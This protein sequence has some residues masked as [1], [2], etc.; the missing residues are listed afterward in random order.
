[1]RSALFTLLAFLYIPTY[2]VSICRLGQNDKP[3]LVIADVTAKRERMAGD[4]SAFG[5]ANLIPGLGAHREE[6]APWWLSQ[7]DGLRRVSDTVSPRRS[8]ERSGRNSK[9]L[10]RDVRMAD[11][12]RG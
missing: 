6:A 3:K 12:V 1:M 10:S 2:V 9:R 4:A 7:D 8:A 11:M 5:D